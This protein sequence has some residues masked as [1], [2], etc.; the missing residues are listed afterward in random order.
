MTHVVG[1]ALVCGL[2]YALT[3]GSADPIDFAT[4]TLLG[5][6]LVWLLRSRLRA[7]AG[8]RPPLWRRLVWFPVFAGAV[9]ADALVGTWDVALRVLHVRSI[10]DQGFV[11]VP[12][13]DRTERGLAVSTLVLTLSPGAMLIEVDRDRGEM[14]FH[15][16]DASDPEA[17]RQ[18]Q[19]R[20]YD[21]YQSRVFP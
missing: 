14:L 3:L 6:V 4:G 5:G 18:R 10:Q 19:L 2:V 12:I 7:P 13:G 15:C 11:W 21:R 8:P 1:A 20:F 16:I 17:V 9:L